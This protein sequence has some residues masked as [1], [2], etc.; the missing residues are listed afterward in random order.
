MYDRL[1][2]TAFLL[3]QRREETSFV[4]GRGVL[5]NE[6]HIA[7]QRALNAGGGQRMLDVLVQRQRDGRRRRK[8]EGSHLCTPRRTQQQIADMDAS[9]GDAA[10]RRALARPQ[11]ADWCAHRE[12]RLG[13]HRSPVHGQRARDRIWH[14]AQ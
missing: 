4:L 3:D 2:E 1:H 11:W 10:C 14:K 13:E 9:D 8:K 12:D 5:R 6:L 7:P